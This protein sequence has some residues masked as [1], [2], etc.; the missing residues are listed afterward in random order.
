MDWRPWLAV[1]M[2]LIACGAAYRITMAKY[3]P[4]MSARIELPVPLSAFPLNIGD[5]R[6]EERP[7]TPEIEHIAGNDDYTHRVYLNRATG[8]G[9]FFYIAYSGRPATMIG[10]RPQ[11]CYVGAGWIN[12]ASDPDVVASTGGMRLPCLVHRFHMPPPQSS[13]VVVLNY[14]VLNGVPTNDEDQFTGVG[15]RLPNIE[16]NPAR[17]VAQV[18]IASP[19]EAAVRHFAELTADEVLSRLPDRQGQVKAATAGAI[20]ATTVPAVRTR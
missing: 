15:M 16:G 11:V 12:D 13:N 7:L 9:V 20:G 17:Y 6:G 8:E 14:Y 19:S 10:H 4:L 18:Q 5:W 3:R 1:C 2:V